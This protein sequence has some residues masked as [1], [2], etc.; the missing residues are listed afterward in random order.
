[1]HKRILIPTDGSDVSKNAISEGIDLAKKYNAKV[2]GA[3]I[4]D[5]NALNLMDVGAEEYE[6][7]RKEHLETGKKALETLKKLASKHGTEIET[8]LREGEPAKEILNIAKE[9]HVDLIVAGTHRRK[10]LKKLICGSVSNKF[11][12]KAPCPVMVAD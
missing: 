12:H 2:I 11:I 8:V 10:G 3:Y 6:R 9:Q 7:R 5:I 1:M 4:L